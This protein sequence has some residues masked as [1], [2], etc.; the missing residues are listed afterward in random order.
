MFVEN[1]NSF[2]DSPVIY[3]G[4][5]YSPITH[6][7]IIETIDEFFIKKGIRITSQ[8]YSV[9]KN[10]SQVVGR[11]KM[12]MID[13]DL[14]QMLCWKNSL[15]GSMAFGVG[16]GTIV[17]IC[18]NGMI[19]SDG[20]QFKRKH[21]GSAKQEIVEALEYGIETVQRVSETHVRIKEDLKNIMLNIFEKSC[22]VGQLFVQYPVLTPTQVSVVKKEIF[23]PT[24]NYKA[25]DTAW[26]LY[27]YCTFSLKSTNPKNW[28]KQHNGLSQFFEKLLDT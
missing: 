8:N 18:S 17:T 28:L 16:T 7:E 15:D 14:H 1:F 21:T 6:R 19:W 24:Y 4:T 10:G 11:I 25:P 2:I 23:N 13:S 12:E 20:A 27:N 3:E 9:N 22:I 26:E 5:A